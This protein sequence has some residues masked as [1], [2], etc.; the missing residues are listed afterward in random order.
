MS[1]LFIRRNTMARWEPRTPKENL[2]SSAERLKTRIQAKLAE[3]KA[4][5]GQ[6]KQ[7]EQAVK[8]LG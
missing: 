4:L 3:I 2:Q 1:P 6:L 5:E 7:V 8:A